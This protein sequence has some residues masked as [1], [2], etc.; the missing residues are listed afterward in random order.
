MALLAAASSPSAPP[1]S[2]SASA[3]TTRNLRDDDC[4]QIMPVIDQWWGG[5]HVADMLP[6]LFFI[7]FRQTSFAVE[8]PLT[9]NVVAFLVGFVSQTDPEQAYIHF[10]GVHP[11]YRKRGLAR[12]LYDT[13]FRAVR[14]LGCRSVHCVT[15]PINR[16]SIAFHKKIGFAI[17]RGD[18]DVDGIPVAANYDGRGLARVLFTKSVD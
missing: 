11:N 3:F 6:R 18:G 2:S 16:A 5:R 8:D 7:H 1:P 9:G 14:A 17:E 15:S 12:G 10:A 13:F 4:K